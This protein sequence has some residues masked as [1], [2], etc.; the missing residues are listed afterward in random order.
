M[1]NSS[2]HGIVAAKSPTNGTLIGSSLSLI[3]REEKCDSILERVTRDLLYVPLSPF[4]PFRLRPT[5]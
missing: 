3:K 1:W 4:S 2:L 5:D